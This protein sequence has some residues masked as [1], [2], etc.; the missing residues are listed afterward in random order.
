MK[1]LTAR[2]IQLS[3]PSL[4]NKYVKM[5]SAVKIQF[6]IEF[7]YKFVCNDEK[8]NPSFGIG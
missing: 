6:C 8:F 4:M 3:R 2:S 7:A 1:T 5:K